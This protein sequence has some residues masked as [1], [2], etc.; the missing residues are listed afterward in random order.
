MNQE[1]TSKTR[2]AP[3]VDRAAHGSPFDR[4]A[5]AALTGLLANPAI[6]TAVG[7]Q[8]WIN[9]TGAKLPQHII[10]AAMGYAK[11][12]VETRQQVMANASDQT[13]ARK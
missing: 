8:A 7:A 4:Y 5:C 9:D 3:A 1:N 10:H 12:A 2:S 6:M 13:T 11:L